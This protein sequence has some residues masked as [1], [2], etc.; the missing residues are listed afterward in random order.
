M[1]QQELMLLPNEDLVT[2]KYFPYQWGKAP[3]ETVHW[4]IV[5]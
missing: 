5:Q 2:A 1:P 3:E 4:N